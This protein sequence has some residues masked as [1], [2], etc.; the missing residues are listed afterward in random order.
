VAALPAL[1]ALPIAAVIVAP[2]QGNDG[3]LSASGMFAVLV[4][5]GLA[6]TLALTWR[7]RPRA[8]AA[9]ALGVVAWVVGIAILVGFSFDDPIVSDRAVHCG[10]GLMGLLMILVPLLWAAF[11]SG[12]IA[13]GAV[14]ANRASDPFIRIAAPIAVVIAAA[15]FVH[16]VRGGAR[17]SASAF[18]ASLP[19]QADIRPGEATVIGEQSLRYA[20]TKANDAPEPTCLLYVGTQSAEYWKCP[21][22]RLRF[23]A[24]SRL[25]FVTPLD[26]AGAEGLAGAFAIET[27]VAVAVRPSMLAGRIAAPRAWVID[28]AASALLAFLLLLVSTRVRR[29]IEGTEAVH[30]GEGAIAIDGVTV[31][32]PLAIDL[33]LGPVVVRRAEVSPTY[34]T[35]AAPSIASVEA[36]TLASLEAAEIDRVTSVRACAIAIALLGAAPLLVAWSHGI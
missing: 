32:A 6:A 31:H 19:P 2:L 34:R 7:K 23:D 26:G 21:S 29:R 12:S 35:H 8:G 10:T 33:P 1:L 3:L 11:T 24:V 30:E 36:G 14:G 28:A 27:G 9:A 17:P 16:G 13:L 4:A 18:V 5:I 15:A 25:L 20:E 22:L